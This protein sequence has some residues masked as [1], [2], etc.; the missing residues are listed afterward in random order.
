[1]L[2]SA[3]AGVLARIPLHGIDTIKARLQVKRGKHHSSFIKEAMQ[4][5]RNEGIGGLYRGIGI[6]AIGS[7]P[8]GCLYFTSYEI[9]KSSILNHSQIPEFAVHFC[10]G[11]FAEATSC[12]IWVPIDVVK[13]RMQVQSTFKAGG[14]F[15]KN[16]WDA[17]RNIS[18]TEGIRGIYRGYGAT[19]SSFGPFSAFYLMFYEK[20]K[21]A[22]QQWMGKDSPL[23]LPVY[24]FMIS[25][26]AAGS[27]A[28]FIT[29]P[30]DLAKLRIQ[31]ER[32]GGRGEGWNSNA[33]F[34]YGNVLDGIR[35]IH[36]EEGLRGMFKGV[37]PRMM[38]HG[39]ATA[40]TITLY[41]SLKQVYISAL[42]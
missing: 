22:C 30:L 14:Y 33:V 8:A 25:G 41:E 5:I 1:M 6:S 20:F 29:N 26:M 24:A 15:Y 2:A 40:L 35:K 16:S 23:D 34:R 11:L 4:V 28:S 17:V 7:I 12:V 10:S 3:S 31:V 36:S 32:S 38:F 9:C 39:P 21:N 13:E 42:S 37:F 19:I 27:L 18:R